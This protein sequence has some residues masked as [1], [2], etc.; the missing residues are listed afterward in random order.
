MPILSHISH[1]F[2]LHYISTLIILNNKILNFQLIYYSHIEFNLLLH[3]FDL[4]ALPLT[5]NII[6]I[7]YIRQN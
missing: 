3:M 4:Q 6:N 1:I 7:A 5:G 2:L